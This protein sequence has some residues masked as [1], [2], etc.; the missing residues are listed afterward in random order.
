[1]AGGKA[2]AKKVSVAQ[3]QLMAL[4]MRKSGASYRVIGESIRAYILQETGKET[5]YDYRQAQKDVTTALAEVRGRLLDSA[6]NVLTT[7]LLRLDELQSALWDKALAG[8]GEAIRLTLTVMEQRA[9]MLGLNQLNVIH[10]LFNG[11]RPEASPVLINEN[12]QDDD[13]DHLIGNLSL[14]VGLRAGAL[15][16]PRI[17]DAAAT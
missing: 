1:M 11:S 9:K 17:I 2:S 5:R 10:L 6:E 12:I 4:E 3:R 8:D 14:L 16:P 13:L 7:E 15:P